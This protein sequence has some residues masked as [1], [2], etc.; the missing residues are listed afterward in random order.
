MERP[1]DFRR[2]CDRSLAGIDVLRDGFKRA[3]VLDV[4]ETNG[5]ENELFWRYAPVSYVD[6][7]GKI[8]VASAPSSRQVSRQ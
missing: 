6:L 4:S 1:G 7:P 2:L 5:Q 8:P 3:E